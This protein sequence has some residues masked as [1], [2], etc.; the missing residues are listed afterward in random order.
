MM[1][2]AIFRIMLHP[3]TFLLLLIFFLA[4]AFVALA[5][6]NYEIQVY[7]SETQDPGTTMFEL[8]SNFTVEGSKGV[9]EGVYGTEHQL[10]ETLEITQGI[11][12]WFETGFYVFT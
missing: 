4:S 1:T 5:Q 6:G 10:H 9:I 3:R 12:N 2:T 8:H 7:G 11:T